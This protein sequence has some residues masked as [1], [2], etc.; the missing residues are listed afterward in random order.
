MRK[1]NIFCYEKVNQNEL[2]GLAGAFG[3]DLEWKTEE[4][5]D[6]FLSEKEGNIYGWWKENPPSPILSIK[7]NPIFDADSLAM[8]RA[9]YLLLAEKKGYFLP[10][11]ILTGIRPGKIVHK[12]R[13]QNMPT[14][15][16]FRF[17]TEE[18]FVHEEKVKL[19]LK[20]TEQESE[21]LRDKAGVS[22]YFHIPFCPSKCSYCS[23]Y[24]IS[25]EK[26]EVDLERYADLLIEEIQM[27]SEKAQNLRV[28]SV[29]IG[30]GT[31]SC[32][33]SQSWDRIFTALK[34]RFQ[35]S[36]DC[37]ITFELG[38]PELAKKELLDCLLF[39]GV[40]RLSLNAQTIHDKTLEKIGRKHT[41][42][43]FQSA[44]EQ[45]RTYP[46]LVNTDL[47]YGLPGE[48]RVLFLESVKTISKMGFENITIHALSLKTGSELKNEG[49][50]LQLQHIDGMTE[51]YH[52]LGKRGYYPY[53]LYRQKRAVDN[54]EN[55]GFS[56]KNQACLYNVVMIEETQ[57][58]LAF[59]AGG[60][61][62]MLQ[63]KKLFRLEQPKMLDNYKNKLKY[64][65][66]QKN[67]MI[68]KLILESATK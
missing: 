54:L 3:V 2:Q 26:Q 50:V 7:A 27:V 5:A 18:L 28:D 58:V 23:F 12:L 20:V 39:H 57:P 48:N 41:F 9:F 61:T 33:H 36:A 65:A 25:L 45:V 40:T 64:L 30:G 32:V 10:W 1:L 35:I 52:I 55:V 53:Y 51:A 67:E 42:K 47:I 56:K 15:E 44:Y 38:R 6:L 21:L 24:S 49:Y 62:K 8:K 34:S 68:E 17:L 46:F 14:E 66:I 63:N 59:G 11:G 60:I 16:I 37:E 43:E 4:E 29:Y 31:P 22:L 19:L 13:N